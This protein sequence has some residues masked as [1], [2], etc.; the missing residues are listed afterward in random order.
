MRVKGVIVVNKERTKKRSIVRN[1]L[2]LDDVLIGI[3]KE[4]ELRGIDRFE[5]VN[6]AGL[7][8]WLCNHKQDIPCELRFRDVGMGPYSEVLRQSLSNLSASGMI[9]YKSND[10]KYRYLEKVF[11]R[12]FDK[13]QKELFER[14][15]ISDEK[16]KLLADSFIQ[17]LCA[18]KVTKA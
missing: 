11:V 5:G 12:C 13:Y 3:F 18:V 2:T 9:Y 6:L 15:G 7:D 8:C 17:H 16:L 1:V 14:N 4:L 10:K